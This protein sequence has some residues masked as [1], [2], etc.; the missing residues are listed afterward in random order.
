MRLLLTNDDGIESKALHILAKELEK[1]HE[2]II[3]APSVQ[4]SACSHSI[5]ISEPLIIKNV[6][7]PDIKSKAFSI[8]GTPAD[9][10]RVA[11]HK[12]LNKPI[13]MVI[14]GTN[15]GTNLGMD[16]IYSGTVSAAIE[17]AIYKIPSIAISAEL[18]NNCGNYNSA[19]KFASKI[20]K[21]AEDNSIKN[22]LVIN[23]NV[24]CL[25]E[26][27][28]KGIQV[29]EMGGKTYDNYFVESIDKNGNMNLKLSGRINT[30]HIENTDIY[31]L[32]KGYVTV[33]PL[34][35]DL[36]NFKILSAVSNWF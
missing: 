15:M 24:P 35:Y 16:I 7:L 14:S 29:C 4:R 18:N 1:N 36:T 28:I 3:A 34:H 11:I 17:A 8:S 26:E 5:T 19:A 9:C 6:D 31:Y 13:D 20:I 22:D 32:K 25:T 27:E 2:L 12:L 33:T 21:I 30:K 10:V 23:V